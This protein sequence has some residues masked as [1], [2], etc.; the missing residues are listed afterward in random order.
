[1]TQLCIAQELK[2]GEITQIYFDDKD[3]PPTLY[4]M[5]TGQP[6]TA[7]LQVRL[8]NDYSPEKQ[9]SA[10]AVCSRFSRQTRW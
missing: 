2:A 9:L 10:F 3:F 1:M 7:T 6:S 4:T 5:F 8:P